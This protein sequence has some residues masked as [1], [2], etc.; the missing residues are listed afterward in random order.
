[1]L[2][3]GSEHRLHNCGLAVITFK[4]TEDASKCAE[5]LNGHEFG[6]R[7]ISIS[8]DKFE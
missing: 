4:D 3:K 6:G 7:R 2:K 8:T 5:K 1:M